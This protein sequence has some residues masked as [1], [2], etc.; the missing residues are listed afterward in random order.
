MNYESYALIGISFVI[1][2][3]SQIFDFGF[4]QIVMRKT[5]LFSSGKYSNLDLKILLRS[6]EIFLLIFVI[7]IMFFLVLYSE[8]IFSNFFNADYLSP[9]KGSFSIILIVLILFAK[10]FYGLY[11]GGIQG[12]EKFRWIAVVSVIFNILRY[13][14]GLLLLINKPDINIFFIFQLLISCIEL[15]IFR[16]KYIG[17]FHTEVKNNFYFSWRHLINELNFSKSLTFLAIL[18]IL[19]MHLDKFILMNAL[20]ME[21]FGFFTTIMIFSTGLLGMAVP[22]GNVVIARLTFMNSDVNIKKIENLYGDM[23]QLAVL[24]FFP[25]AITIAIYSWEFIFLFTSNTEVATWGELILSVFMIGNIFYIMGT[26][27]YYL[28]LSNGNL[29]LHTR[30]ATF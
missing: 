11:R 12:F 17:I 1:N 4:H 29:N 30:Y 25:V 24:I 15:F 5:T 2:S 3:F 7:F 27:Q 14:G 9:E 10:S 23:S 16:S 13:P 19:S 20:T 18:W 6:I 21:E 26:F 8:L 28:Q 22:F